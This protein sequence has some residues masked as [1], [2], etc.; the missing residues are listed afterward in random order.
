MYQISY[1]KQKE[2]DGGPHQTA[3]CAWS[4]ILIVHIVYHIKYAEDASEEEHSDTQNK[5][6][7]IE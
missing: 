1:E 2:T 6:P 4:D 5:Y 7:R 3:R